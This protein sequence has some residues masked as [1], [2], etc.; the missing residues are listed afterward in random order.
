MSKMKRE[1]DTYACMGVC[2]FYKQSCSFLNERLKSILLSMN[3]FF[4]TLLLTK[5]S[6]NIVLKLLIA[7]LPNYIHISESLILWKLET[8]Q[9][10]LNL[11]RL[12]SN[13][14]NIGLKQVSEQVLIS[15]GKDKEA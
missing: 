11:C 10:L 15:Y 5:R 6:K 3:I 4:F 1:G 12:S 2:Y 8:L 9:N 13:A 7:L 14:E